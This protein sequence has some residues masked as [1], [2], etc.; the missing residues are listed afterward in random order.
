MELEL[1]VGRKL[2]RSDVWLV[3]VIAKCGQQGGDG[4]RKRNTG[5]KAFT[6]NVT[7]LHCRYQVKQANQIMDH[8]VVP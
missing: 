4:H 8:I 1:G 3:L 7:W 5:G 2:G 6:E